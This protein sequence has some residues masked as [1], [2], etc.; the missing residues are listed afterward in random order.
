[1]TILSAPQLTLEFKDDG[2]VL[3][4][5]PASIASTSSGQSADLFLLS[6]LPFSMLFRPQ[7]ITGTSSPARRTWT[8]ASST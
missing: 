1:M 4:K 2:G 3:L 7:G 5:S 6:R 8:R